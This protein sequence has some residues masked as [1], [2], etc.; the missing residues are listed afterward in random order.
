M[1]A[2]VTQSMRKVAREHGPALALALA[3]FAVGAAL[4]AD[5]GATAD[6]RETLVAGQ[7]N[8]EIAASFF[9]GRPLPEWSFHELTGYSFALDTLCALW[10]RAFAAA[11][12]DD[13]W[14]ALHLAHLALA[15]TTLY[16]V[17]RIASTVGASARAAL[18]AAL[19]LATLPPFV[20]H[21]QNNPKDLPATFAL[22]LAVLAL[23]RAAKSARPRDAIAG[24]AALGLALTTRIHALFG[25]FA[26]WLYVLASS[27]RLTRRD[28]ALQALALAMG[29]VSA[30]ALWPWLW[31]A[32]AERLAAAIGDVG[33]KIFALPVLYLGHVYPAHEVPWHYR[34]VLLAASTPI[35]T[36]AV[37][38]VGLAAIFAR[39]AERGTRSIAVLGALWCAAF[40][41]AE[42]IVWSRYDG[43]RHALPSL[44]GAALVVAAGADVLWQRG[45]AARALALAPFAIAS[46]ELA[47]LHPYAS[48]YLNAPTRLAL[49]G[50]SDATFE[51]EYWGQSYLEG[52]RW[53][54]AN[55]EP[56]A[57]IVVPQFAH[58][59]DEYL[60]LPVIEAGIREWSATDRPRYLVV[61]SRRA[62]WSLPLAQ[63]ALS[64]AADFEIRRSG[65]RLLAIFRNDAAR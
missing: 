7:R 16:L 47:A 58:I 3:Y 17:A 31:P 54:E 9:A 64:R 63:V 15:S 37:G 23:L 28:F 60:D 36:M 21:S 41:L 12:F 26:A 42:A 2:R 44:P 45:R 65:G 13:A 5:I 34:F 4:N 24:G 11:G 1:L 33:T 50:D 61:M 22:A 29:V 25:V 32:P 8:L 39:R 19:A 55:A 49:R 38:V 48:A 57:E 62:Y 35:A 18:F 53:L 27:E 46:L 10:I 43:V 40:V 30:L 20:A 56:E 52:A 59:A 51:I 6:E 14:R